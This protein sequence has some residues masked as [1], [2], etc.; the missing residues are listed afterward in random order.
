VEAAK[1][2]NSLALIN[3]DKCVECGICASNC[4]QNTISDNMLP[5]PSVFITDACNGCTICAK[6]CPFDAIEGQ[7]KELHVVDSERCTGCRLCVE[8]CNVS[9][10]VVTGENLPVAASN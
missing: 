5:R 2:D 7:A 3:P 1:V 10:I 8:K 9:A 4:P 6:V